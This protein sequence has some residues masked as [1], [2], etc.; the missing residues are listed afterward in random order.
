MYFILASIC[1]GFLECGI[2]CS[3]FHSK[4]LHKLTTS[5]LIALLK[6]YANFFET[7]NFHSP[8]PFFNVDCVMSQIN[9]SHVIKRLPI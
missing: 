5:Y 9:L 2:A 3:V 4:R 1:H 8:P 6:K 7:R